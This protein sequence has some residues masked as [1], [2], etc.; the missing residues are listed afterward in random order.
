M[1]NDKKNG[2]GGFDSDW[3]IDWTQNDEFDL[4]EF[5]DIDSLESQFWAPYEASRRGSQGR[6]TGAEIRGQSDSSQRRQAADEVRRQKRRNG[7]RPR[8]IPGILAFL[9]YLVFVVGGSMGLAT[10]GWIAANDVLALNKE[11]A[12]AVIELTSDSTVKDVAQTLKEEGIIDYPWLFQLYC[13]FTHSESKLSYGSSE[14]NTDMDYHALVSA[15]SSSSETRTEIDV[16]IPEGYTIDQIFDLLVEKG[17]CE[18]VEELQ[19]VAADHDYNFS[20][21]KDL[22]LGDYH[23]L[24]GYLFPDTYKFYVGHDPLY[25]INKMLVNFDSQYTD[26]MRQATADMG[27]SM[28]DI[29]T[30]AS[31]IEKETNG[32][33]Q[34]NIASVIYNRLDSDVTSG[35]LQIDATVQYALERSGVGRKDTLT[36]TDLL[37]DSEYNT[38]QNTGL[39]AGPIC[40]PSLV[41]IQAALN[42]NS[43][44]FYYYLH[45][46]Y[47]ESHFYTNSAEFEEGKETYLSEDYIQEDDG[48][49]YEGFDENGN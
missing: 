40:N 44:G 18:S 39:P 12:T 20:F 6:S 42:P 9:I 16:T 21:L 1:A 14:V 33:D 35:Y 34:R 2:T 7:K 3:S 24:E 49:N 29:L 5:E 10:L 8:R 43:T 23:R 46:S 45:D 22:P 28:A 30:I 13:A 4:D 47:G 48:T 19:E 25:V 27:Y 17:V 37:V 26:E 11:P 38:Y 41:S 36:S 32:Q 15:M 31:M